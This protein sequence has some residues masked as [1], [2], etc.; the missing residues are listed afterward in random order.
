M[1]HAGARGVL[2]GRPALSGTGT[3]S[4]A[5]T[6][7]GAPTIRR[8]RSRAVSDGLLL[9]RGCT[10][11]CCRTSRPPPIFLI[12]ELAILIALTLR[13][14]RSAVNAVSPSIPPIDIKAGR[15]G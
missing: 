4:F 6:R 3:E 11:R 14:A 2:R 9:P 13:L 12:Y 15:T 8:R 7:R 5:A 10:R 1:H